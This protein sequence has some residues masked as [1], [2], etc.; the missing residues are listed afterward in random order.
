MP[1]VRIIARLA[2]YPTEL[3]R[4]LRARGFD[5]ETCISRDEQQTAAGLEITI[6]QCSPENI[7]QSVA[8]A[9]TTKDVVILANAQAQGRSIRSIG[10]VLL[11]S[12]NSMQTDRKTVVP[13]WTFGSENTCNVCFCE[14][15][16]ALPKDDSRQPSVVE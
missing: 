6:D 15:G 7:S 5:V 12:E 16:G 13:S 10:M 11:S 2:E 9:M 4:D 3:V 8:D 1:L 14:F